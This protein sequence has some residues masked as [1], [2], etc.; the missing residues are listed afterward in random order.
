MGCLSRFKHL[1]LLVLA[2]L[3]LTIVQSASAF[4]PE[5][6]ECIAPSDPGGG[7]DF[8]CRTVGKLLQELGLVEGA[9]QTQNMSGGGGGV[10]YGYMVGKRN[11][12]PNLIVAASTATTSRL[13]Q[14]QYAG[15]SA[16]QVRWVAALGADFGAIAV[17]A[18]SPYQT[19]D[20]LLGA[21]KENPGSVPFGGG[22]AVGGWDHLKVLMLANEAGIEELRRIKYVSFSSG[23]NAITQMLGGHIGAFSGDVS[24]I[25]GQMEAGNVRML[26]V[27]A[28]ER[29]PE[30][31]AD[32]PTAQEQGYDVVGANWRG[33]Y[34]GQEVSD[35][36][37]QWWVDAL[38][39]LYGSE[40]WKEAMTRNGLAPFWRGGEAFEQFVDDQI[41][42]LQ[43]LSR[44]IGI[45][46]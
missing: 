34:M 19:L 11:D 44:E 41:D 14:N 23:G 27:L 10:A 21:L 17:A 12:D 28:D 45:I 42:D 39:Q 20:D 40:A 2:G 22:S 5:R 36:A 13:A 32:L 6:V 1:S 35:E 38:E 18:D 30:Q 43:D 24:E 3:A 7:W 26:A 29:L 4:E 25:K 8:T 37:Y 15:L 31:L 9:V 16:D 33:F 46:Q